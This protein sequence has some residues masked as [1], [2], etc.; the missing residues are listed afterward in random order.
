MPDRY[1]PLRDAIATGPTKGPWQAGTD[2]KPDND[3]HHGV[4]AECNDLWIAAM[5]R[6]GTTVDGDD[7]SPKAEA[8]AAANARYVAAA[9]PDTIDALLKERD[10]LREALRWYASMSKRMGNASIAGDSQAILA[11]MKDVAVD[12]GGRARAALARLNGDGH[13]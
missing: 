8:E 7:R 9:D 13:D 2:G 10:A 11:L 3:M 1:Q 12:Y 5:Y 4:I 6:S